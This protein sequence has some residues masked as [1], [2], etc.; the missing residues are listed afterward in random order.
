MA[1]PCHNT[2]VIGGFHTLYKTE[3]GA[4]VEISGIM[5]QRPED[6]P[7]GGRLR[8]ILPPLHQYSLLRIQGSDSCPPSSIRRQQPSKCRNVGCAPYQKREAPRLLVILGFLL[9]AIL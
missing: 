6:R 3:A 2:C 1:R 4:S 9:A 8:W 5:R 7:S